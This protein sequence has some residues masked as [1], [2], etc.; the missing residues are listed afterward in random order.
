MKTKI[1]KYKIIDNFLEKN[2]FLELKNILESNTFPWYFQKLINQYHNLN[3]TT[4]YFTHKI[5]EDKIN[6]NII[7]NRVIQIILNKLKIK[8]LIRIKCN[9][10]MGTN[11]LEIHKPHIDYDF[12]HKAAILYI[13]TNNGSTILDSDYKSIYIKSIENRM[14]FFE[15]HKNHS[16]T[17]TTDSKCRININFNYL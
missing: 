8:K 3:D 12:K 7:N 2:N 17:S 9:L 1:N 16:S 6:S 11:I 14:L 15:G 13:N 5:F 10:Y 4:C